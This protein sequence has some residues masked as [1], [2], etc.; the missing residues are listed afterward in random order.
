M[1]PRLI[2]FALLAVSLAARET[3]LFND[4]WQF[5]LGD[6]SNGQTG[7]PES[8]WRSLSLPHDWSAELD[9]DPENAASGTAFLPGGIGWYRKSFS[10]PAGSEGQRYAI[11]FDGISRHSDVWINGEHLGHR[12]SAYAT[13]QYDLTPHLKFGEENLLTV[14]VA[15]EN[16]A[17]SRWYPGSGIYRNVHLIQTGPVHFAADGIAITTP[18]I[19][20]E[21]ADI[22]SRLEVTNTL[23]EP[24]RVRVVTEA[25]SPE[26]EI[27][28][29][30]DDRQR[31][32]PGETHTFT[33]WQKVTEPRL[34]SPDTPTLYTLR[35][36]VLIGGETVDSREISFGIR[37]LRFDPSTGFYLNGKNTIMKG[38]CIHHDGGVVGAAVPREVWARRLKIAKEAGVN[39]IRCSHNP[40]APE[41]YELCDQM[42]FLVMDEAFDE[43]EIGK[44]K[45]VKGRNEGRA[46]RFGYAEDFEEWATRDLAAMIRQHRNHPSI[47]MW[48]IGN[49]IDYPTDPYVHP[50]SRVDNDFAKFST[51]GRPAAARL[52]A[53]APDLIATVKKHDP[54]RPV[55]MAL[56]NVPAANGTGLADML[57]VAGYNYQEQFYEQDHAQFPG[58]FIYGSE[59]G[60]G[61]GN[62]EEVTANEFIS[63]LFLWVG[64]DFLGEANTWPNHGSQAGLW[65]R[66]G[67]P[68]VSGYYIDSAW[69][70][71]PVLH[72][73]ATQRGRSRS[74]WHHRPHWTWE[75]G[76]NVG[77]TAVT[78]CE[79]IEVTLNDRPIEMEENSRGFRAR[80]D[81]EPGELIAVGYRGG[82]EVIRTT[83]RTAEEP[84]QILISSD[85]KSLQAGETAHL[86]ITVVD[87]NG[88]RVPHY[89]GKVAA[90]ITGSGK[91][92]GLD[93]GNQND[94]T[95]LR[96][97]EKK[98]LAG[99]LL[100]LVQASEG[101]Q[102]IKVTL[103]A[104]G[105]PEASVVIPVQT[106]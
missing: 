23:K 14:K 103:E 39:A 65:D 90:R 41:I 92:L 32:S 29:A 86:E 18:R 43:W 58:R 95:P 101:N 40:M 46:S 24:T 51:E 16:V 79:R 50:E 52:A 6:L 44:R 63:G 13:F 53:V 7:S 61:P 93:N 37:S 104:E 96:S 49:E 64:F 74:W 4:D 89:D 84:A 60:K 66:C 105:L 100:A 80:L 8:E 76:E 88:T 73:L 31:L 26:G 45:W 94:P 47:I 28:S 77:L 11:R 91:L 72:L 55:T 98:A 54:T 75:E 87:A 34:W 71:E 30:A 57:D 106:Q 1:L 25:V 15:R 9:F 22:S 70:D 27:L 48:S 12:P 38:I 33:T 68:R 99:R 67:Y 3:T 62:W 78:N 81:F 35:C 21:N 20:S 5:H 59:T 42:G 69:N 36:K 17:D 102:E 85:R 97:R 82:K 19:S 56:A 10:L 83:L 2:L